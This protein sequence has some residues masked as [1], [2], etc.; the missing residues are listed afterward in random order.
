MS[1]LKMIF[2]EAVF[3]SVNQ[4]FVEAYLITKGNIFNAGAALIQVVP[5]TDGCLTCL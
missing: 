3:I 4:L 5:W 2:N 1:F